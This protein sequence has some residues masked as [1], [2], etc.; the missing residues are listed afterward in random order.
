MEVIMPFHV[1]DLQVKEYYTGRL[2]LSDDMQQTLAQLTGY[3]TVSRKLLKCS[4]GGILYVAA[5]RIDDIAQVIASGANYNWQGSDKK[6]TEVM[7]MGHPANTGLVYVK[8]DQIATVDN[9]WPLA[10]KEVIGVT[11]ENLNNLHLLIVVDGE[12]AILAYSR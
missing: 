6:A 1:E 7:I 11:L 9:S 2:R 3:D 10:A 8:N 4:T 12:R 5:P